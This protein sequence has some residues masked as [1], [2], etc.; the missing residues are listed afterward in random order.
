MT[1]EVQY[2]QLPKFDQHV[3]YWQMHNAASEAVLQLQLLVHELRQEV[4]AL[5]AQGAPA[6]AATARTKAAS[7]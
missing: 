5:K 4:A 6:K 2:K 1:E 3:D 7:K